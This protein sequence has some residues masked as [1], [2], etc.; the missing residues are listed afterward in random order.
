[1]RLAKITQVYVWKTLFCFDFCFLLNLKDHTEVLM[2]KK[3]KK[4]QKLTTIKSV[5]HWH[6]HDSILLIY[7]I[8][9]IFGRLWV[10]LV[11]LEL[12]MLFANYDA[13][14]CANINKNTNECKY[15]HQKNVIVKHSIKFCRQTFWDFFKLTSN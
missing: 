8:Y 3:K 6:V 11:C 4:K 1:M 10:Y 15:Q 7:R 14:M 12:Q 5:K 13:T 2:Q 9:I